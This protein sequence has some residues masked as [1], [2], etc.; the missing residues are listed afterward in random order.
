MP[1]LRFYQ[2]KL[3]AVWVRSSFHVES[4]LF[5]WQIV[6]PIM[7]QNA[8]IDFASGNFDFRVGRYSYRVW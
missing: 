3:A 5:S 2:L 4:T 1:I 6:E 8:L 7:W